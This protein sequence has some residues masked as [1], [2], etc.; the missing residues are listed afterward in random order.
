[1]TIYICTFA[2]GLSSPLYCNI[3][4]TYLEHLGIL[5]III[6]IHYIDDFMLISAMSKR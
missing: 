6:S 2:S 4:Q 1:M 3:V 5:Q